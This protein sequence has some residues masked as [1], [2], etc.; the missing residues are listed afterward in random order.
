MVGKT[1]EVLETSEVWR[2][3]ALYSGLG[4]GALS[5]LT[6][7]VGMVGL[8]QPLV[9]WGMVLLLAVGMR[10][11]LTAVFH[12]LRQLSL[13]KP[14]THFERWLAI[15]AIANLLIAFLLA[16]TPETA[17]DALTYHLTGPQ[18]FAN[19]GRITHLRDI[20]FL[21]FPQLGEMQF[22]LGVLL[23]GDSMAPLLHFGY[24][25]MGLIMATTLARQ[26]FG[27]EA[28]WLTAVILLTVPLFLEELGDAYVDL[29]LLFYATA[30][31]YLFRRWQTAPTPRNLVILGL[32]C[33]FAAGV[34]YTAIV[35]PIAMG[36][37]LL[38][39][40]RR[41]P[42]GQ[43]GRQVGGLTAVTTLTTL[44]WLLKNWL[45]TGNPTYPFFF[46]NGLYWDAWRSWSYARPG[47]GLLATAPWRLLTAP[48]EATIL[49]SSGSQYF[50]AT[51]GP[52]V[53]GGLVLL[54]VVW[55][56]LGS[57]EKTAVF[58][59]LT[60]FTINYLFW[61]LGMARSAQLVQSRLLLPLLGITAVLSALALSRLHTLTRPQ[62]NVNWLAQV[63]L[64]LTLALLLLT[65]LTQFVQINPLPVLLGQETVSQFRQRRLGDYQQVLERIN[66]L[67][68]NSQVLF[69][70]E[71][72][73]YGCRVI[74]HPDSMLDFHLHATHYQGQDAATIA[75]AWRSRGLTHVLINHAGLAF[76][77]E[78]G[79][80][81][82]TDRDL[83]ILQQLIDT[84]L[85]P[86][87]VWEGSYT[88][89]ALK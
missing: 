75:A 48:F 8:L 78:Q 74:C 14:T 2:Q 13:P 56:K 27:R 3:L 38:W 39:Q 29:T 86:V 59:L 19:A 5:F 42:W 76:L 49:G 41:E 47:T 88:L 72:R 66:Q 69:L 36:L 51:I 64:S 43:I 11:E 20:A 50:D 87:A 67:P 1:S 55:S 12:T 57:R 85:D 81:P 28:A 61:L 79:F 82:I 21:G 33:G 54:P 84:T 45:T 15:Y 35:I 30:V 73:S 89:Y 62:L 71:P 65:H 23:W 80:E 60:F 6:L 25:V 40:L 7:A 4:L 34:K 53:L 63:A 22:L 77:H 83:A 70:W 46:Q 16:L 68:P 9:A 26:L 24:G 44:P 58:H 17:W 37:A 18:L 31:F 10:R 32:F 52:F